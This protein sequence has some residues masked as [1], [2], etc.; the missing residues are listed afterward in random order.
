MVKLAA[1][2]PE[3]VRST[4]SDLAA[5]QHKDESGKTHKDNTPTYNGKRYIPSDCWEHTD[6]TTP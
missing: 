6:A 5:A 1:F 4:W 2:F 3:T